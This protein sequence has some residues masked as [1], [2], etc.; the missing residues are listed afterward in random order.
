MCCCASRPSIQRSR[1]HSVTRYPDAP[2][3]Q[4]A[5]VIGLGVVL[6]A[7]VLLVA[8]VVALLRAV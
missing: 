3:K 6:V 1:P 5:M 4:A 2:R 8:L 7:V